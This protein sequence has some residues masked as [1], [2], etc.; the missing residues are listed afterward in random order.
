[1]L[2]TQ[3]SR[4]PEIVVSGLDFTF[5]EEARR[6]TRPKRVRFTTDCKFASGCSPPRLAATQLPLTIGYGHLP[7][8]DLHLS[9]RACPQA[10]SFRHTPDSS[11]RDFA[12]KSTGKVWSPA[13]AEATKMQNMCLV[14]PTTYGPI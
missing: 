11:F 5:H 1:V 10:H 14:N 9:D 13:F 3:R 7:R 4:L 6:Y 8:E 2:S 12:V